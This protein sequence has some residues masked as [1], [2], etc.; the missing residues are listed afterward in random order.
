MKKMIPDFKKMSEQENKITMLTAYDFPTA[1]IM[2][3]AGVD[4]ILVGDSLGM[5]V[6]G[7]D[8]TVPV[9][10]EDMLH[11][12]KAVR[13][14]APNTFMI[15]DMPY[16]TY[17]RPKDALRNA[18]RLMQEGGA[19]AVKLEGGEEYREIISFLTK[20]GIPVVGHIGLTPQ[21]AGLLGGYKVQGTE[22]HS[23]SKLLRDAGILA[24]AGVFMLVL[25]A[26]P[27]QLAAKITQ[28]ISVPTIGIGAGN[29]CDGQ[30][31]VI[32]DMIGVSDKTVPT[33][34]KRYEMIEPL[35]VDAVQKYCAE[36]KDAA[37]PS[38]IHSFSM[39]E[40]VLNKLT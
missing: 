24:Q 19:D 37:F 28:S 23:A 31:L 9:T 6:L 20:A 4:V 2:E 15:V 29:Q 21:T 36:V 27:A 1:Q 7:Y 39:K 14:G 11:H 10:M 33:F 12:A 25:E 35:I 3:K 18:G 38:D 13:R 34:V 5:V 32:H 16:L 17:A 22:I 8:S 26:I 40:D 30:V